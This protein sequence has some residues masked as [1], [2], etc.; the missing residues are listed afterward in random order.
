MRTYLVLKER[1]REWNADPE[2]QALVA[3]IAGP[4]GADAASAGY[5]TGRAAAL[6]TREFDRIALG[7][8]GLGYERLD[9]L[10]VERLLGVRP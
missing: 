6:K 1:A 2:I 9:Q 7:A 4:A 10:T 8:R 5:A 3:E